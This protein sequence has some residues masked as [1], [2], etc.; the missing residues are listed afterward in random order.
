M[1]VK[2]KSRQVK[3]KLSEGLVKSNQVKVKSSKGQG[4]GKK[5]EM[6]PSD[7]LTLET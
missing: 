2:S 4:Q 6:V 7:S 1:K 5:K 3:V